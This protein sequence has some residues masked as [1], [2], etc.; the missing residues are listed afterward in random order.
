MKSKAVEY[1]LLGVGVTA[2]LGLIFHNQI[3]TLMIKTYKPTNGDT[4]NGRKSEN[5]ESKL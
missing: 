3:G 5:S 4:K 2:S 1:T